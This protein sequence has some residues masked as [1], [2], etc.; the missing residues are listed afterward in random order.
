[1]ETQVKYKT[2]QGRWILSDQTVSGDAPPSPIDTGG[3]TSSTADRKLE[4]QKKIRESNLAI[5]N[6]D[7]HCA[8]QLYTEAMT[9]DPGN[10]ILHS[11]RSAAYMKTSQYEKALQDAQEARR[12]QPKW[13]KPSLAITSHHQPSLAITS[14]HQPSPAITSYHQPSPAITGYHQPSPAITSHHQLSPAITSYHQPSPAITSYHQ[15]SPAITS[16]HQPS[17]AITSHHQPSPAITSYHQLSPAI[18]S[19][20]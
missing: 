4:F 18:T 6:A 11:N 7:F 15:P 20:H 16:Y 9:L 19:H 1:M 14:H 5:Q 13:P 17:P 3:A 2:E 8:V 12:L 10:H